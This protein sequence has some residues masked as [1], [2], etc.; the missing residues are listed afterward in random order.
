[1]APVKSAVV[2]ANCPLPSSPITLGFVRSV[3]H[4]ALL[5]LL[6][7]SACGDDGSKRADDR[8]IAEAHRRWLG[9]SNCLIGSSL[10]DGETASSR[11]RAIEVTVMAGGDANGDADWTAQCGKTA[12]ALAQ[13]LRT[14]QLD[15]SLEKY[16]PLASAISELQT[17]RPEMLAATSE[18]IVDRL[19]EAAREV[20]LEPVPEGTKAAEGPSAPVATKLMPTEALT[21]LGRSRGFIARTE[22]VPSGSVRFIV[23]DEQS[24]ALYCHLASDA[25]SLDH[26]RC[27]ELTHAV[28]LGATPLSAQRDTADH[29]WDTNPKPAARS[30]SGEVIQVPIG[31][32][33]FVFGDG[34]IADVVATG[35]KSELVRRLPWGKQERAPLQGPPGGEYLGFRGGAALWRGPVRG[36]SGKR[37]LTVQDVQAGRVGIGGA[38]EPGTAPKDVKHL[39][40]CRASEALH[41]MLIGEEPPGQNDG[42]E[43][44]VVL[45]SRTRMR[46]GKP[47][48]VKVP[49]GTPAKSWSEHWWRSLECGEKAV[50]L[51]WLRTDRRVGQVRCAEGSCQ[52]TLSEP[53]PSVGTNDKLR[54]VGIGGKVLVVR[55]MRIVAP[56]TGLTEVISM[57]LAP[58]GDIAAAPDRVLVGDDKFGGPPDLHRSLGL[59][60]AGDAAVALI[61]SSDTVYGLRIDAKGEVGKLALAAAADPPSK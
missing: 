47:V 31:R 40:A 28:G 26:A 21:K 18:P 8:R 61:H 9:L 27:S 4:L 39:V 22:Y 1:M 29:Y 56:M 12:E 14:F 58:V 53:I 33:G 60:A 52:G 41:V 32:S 6:F 38:I 13:H 46:W 19:W 37:G 10:E 55:A 43:R 24:G 50:T 34:T 51:T 5:A 36:R 30:L 49:F 23:G 44:S 16:A 17:T 7:S 20:G 35:R 3:A 15:A 25:A 54:A 48:S 59:V 2:T 42:A 11:L 45:L 57:R